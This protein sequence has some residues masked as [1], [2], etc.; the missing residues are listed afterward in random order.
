MDLKRK[1]VLFGVGGRRDSSFST[2]MHA[3]LASVLT[4]F[5]PLICSTDEL[6]RHVI[7]CSVCYLG[8]FE[9]FSMVQ[10]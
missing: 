9:R 10:S 5:S 3:N 6:A 8:M 7:L 4:G 2:K 1:S